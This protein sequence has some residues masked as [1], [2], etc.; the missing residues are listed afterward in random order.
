MKFQIFYVQS[1]VP[2]SEAREASIPGELCISSQ[3]HVCEGTWPPPAEESVGQK[4]IHKRKE[5]TYQTFHKRN[6]KNFTSAPNVKE[7]PLS[8][9]PHPIVSW[10]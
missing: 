3:S 5:K 6:F 4:Q 1:E 10:K 9:S 7:T 8:F 2:S